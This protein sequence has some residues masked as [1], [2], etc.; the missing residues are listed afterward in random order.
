VAVVNQ[1][2]ACRLWPGQ[3]PIGR[4]LHFFGENWNVEVVGVARDCQ[5]VNLGEDPQGY[6]Y[7]ALDQQMSTGATLYVHSKG[8]IAAAVAPVRGVVQALD[9]HLPLKGEATMPE[10]LNNALQLPRLGA[11][12]L[13]GFGLLALGL[14]AVGIYGVMS[15]SVS[16]RTREVEIR[17]AL[18][19]QAG[20]VMRLVLRHGM[21]IVGA[22]VV[23][24]CCLALA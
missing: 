17:M 23:V 13:G 6:I 14:A 24:G 4:H 11:D 16:Q 21:A 15:Y 12:L 5:Y 20:D 1:T 18:G 22:G 19:A 3:D 10:I 8:D 9:S 7:F 2:L